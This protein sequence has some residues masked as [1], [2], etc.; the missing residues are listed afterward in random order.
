M[1]ITA[2]DDRAITEVRVSRASDDRTAPD[3]AE[4]SNPIHS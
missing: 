2:V 1:T 3:N 4:D